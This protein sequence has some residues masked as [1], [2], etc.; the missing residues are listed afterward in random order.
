MTEI[1]FANPAIRNLI[2][3]GKIF[4][5]YNVI[6]T[7]QERGMR[8]MN[9]S[10]AT[11]VKNGDISLKTAYSLTPEREELYKLLNRKAGRTVA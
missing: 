8:T 5:I 9:H 4:Q 1:L 11:A 10:L 6:Q 7:S 3:E 2:R